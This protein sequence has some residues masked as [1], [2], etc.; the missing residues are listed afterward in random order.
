MTLGEPDSCSDESSAMRRLT[1]DLRAST[2]PPKKRVQMR[3][4]MGAKGS[5]KPRQS[6]ATLQQKGEHID[7]TE[8]REGGHK[9][10]IPYA[11]DAKPDSN[12]SVKLIPMSG[13]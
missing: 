1:A 9:Q 6:M 12:R 3:F 4:W 10:R 5:F 8:F 11:P 13:A 2:T 7:Y